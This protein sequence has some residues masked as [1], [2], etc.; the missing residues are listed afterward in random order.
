MIASLARTSWKRSDV[1][2][3]AM[4]LLGKVL[5]FRFARTSL[6]SLMGWQELN[7]ARINLIVDFLDSLAGCRRSPDEAPVRPQGVIEGYEQ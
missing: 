3:K 5:V 7:A 1:K 4:T 6:L 2:F